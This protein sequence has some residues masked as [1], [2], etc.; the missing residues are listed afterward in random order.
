[1]L[2][3]S[4]H[5]TDRD[6]DL[7]RLV[8]R[9]R[10]LTTEQLAALRFSNLTTARHRLSVLVGL[11][12]LRRFRPHC[13]RGSAP[14]HY[15]LGP[16]GAALLGQEDREEKKW[17]PQV[18]AD[19]QLALERSQRLGHMTGSNWF[20][21]ALA[22]HAREHGSGELQSWLS[23]QEVTQRLYLTAW[24]ASHDPHPDG[25]GIW[26]EDGKDIVF[27]LEYDIGTEHLPQLTGKLPGYAEHARY[28]LICKAPLL[29]CFPT[30]RREQ[31]PARHRPPAARP[32]NSRSPPPHSTRAPPARLAAPSGCLCTADT[33]RCDSSTWT[34]CSPTPGASNAD[35]QS[36]STTR[37]T[38]TAD[39]PPHSPQRL[40][41]RPGW[42]IT[43]R[44]TNADRNASRQ[45]PDTA[46]QR[47]NIPARR[48]TRLRYSPHHPH[49][50]EEEA[51]DGASSTTANHHGERRRG[52][53][54]SR[55]N[56]DR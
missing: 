43:W 52:T 27:L 54:R 44:P 16:V 9:H 26:A 55:A 21:A 39:D 47:R 10:V 51:Q 22:R 5:L 18:R 14:W 32:A 34:T 17:L 2:A 36:T 30:P 35:R 24:D 42:R 33:A 50:Q 1:V 25:L 12:V 20:F 29:F 23:E 49:E 38:Q 31:T 28:N 37:R 46:G 11:G 40:R 6:R 4:A 13:E 15:V 7:V 53:G 8:A 3:V 56:R 48:R 19:R 41:R 45:M